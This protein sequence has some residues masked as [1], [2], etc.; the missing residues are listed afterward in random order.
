MNFIDNYNIG[1]FCDFDSFIN[2]YKHIIV[3]LY[4]ILN[5]IIINVVDI[6][7]VSSISLVFNQKDYDD[8]P[9]GSNTLNPYYIV[10][11]E[12]G[13]GANL[14]E[15]E[16]HALIAHE[17]GHIYLKLTN[18]NQG[19]LNEELEAD[20]FACSIGLQSALKSALIKVAGIDK[21]LRQKDEIQNRA[22]KL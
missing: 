10:D 8:S 22:S 16:K 9:Y 1:S 21:A 7:H 19:G 5:N 2:K 3:N 17:I 14:T 12:I 4:S 13:F 15:D 6:N 18:A 20:K 11:N